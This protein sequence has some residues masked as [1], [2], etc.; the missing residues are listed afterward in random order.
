MP[1]KINVLATA[2][3]KPIPTKT[4]LKKLLDTGA[5]LVTFLP[6]DHPTPLT[7]NVRTGTALHLPGNVTV[8]AH[9]PTGRKWTAEVTRHSELGAVFTVK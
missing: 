1:N 4:A 3:G 2:F 7:E 5:E 8:I 6:A 9:S